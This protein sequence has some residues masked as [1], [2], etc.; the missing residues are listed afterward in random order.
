MQLQYNS[1]NPVQI[2]KDQGKLSIG[3]APSAYQFDV[4]GAGRFSSFCSANNYIT[5]SDQRI[6]TD[7]EYADPAECLRLVSAVKP[8]T[9]KRLDM[10]LAPRLGYVA[11][12]WDAQL[13]GGYRCIMGAGEDENGPLLALDYSRICPVIHGALLGVMSKL[14]AALARIE[15][16]E[17]RA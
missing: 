17:S 10:N 1:D 11:Q 8:R 12:E 16:L 7:V 6:K 3:C 4:N 15:A 14:E 13:T 2:G 5:T 9:Y